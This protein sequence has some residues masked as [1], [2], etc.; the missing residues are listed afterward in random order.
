MADPF[1]WTVTI[2]LATS[3]LFAMLLCS[4]KKYPRKHRA[5]ALP[6]KSLP[7]GKL[8]LLLVRSRNSPKFLIF[9]GGKVDPG[10]SPEK[11]AMRECFE[12]AGAIGK[13]GLVLGRLVNPR[14]SWL[15]PSYTFVYALHVEE[16]VDEYDESY[17]G[18]EWF[19]L[20]V[21]GSQ[22]SR[23]AFER[24]RLAILSKD[25]HYRTLELIQHAHERILRDCEQ[26]ELAARE[27]R[28]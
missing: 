26:I 6:V 27:G 18:R 14:S 1:Y 13:I 2:L 23:A 28:S 9:P 5:V 12:E 24:L 4:R 15:L 10:E 3:V 8:H 22:D 21:P 7:N 16:E 11:A 17:R 25:M 20:G 19:D